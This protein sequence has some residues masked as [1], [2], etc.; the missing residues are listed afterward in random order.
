LD[1]GRASHD[2]I[3]GAGPPRRRLPRS[4]VVA[5]EALL[6][7]AVLVWVAV[8]AVDSGGG[9]QAAPTP[10]N[11]A[12]LPESG[13]V[14][15][16][17]PQSPWRFDRWARTHGRYTMTAGGIS[18]SY[19]LPAHQSGWEGGGSDRHYVTKSTQG[20]QGAEAII[21]WTSYPDGD[22]ADRC[23]N[24]LKNSVKPTAA[25]LAAAVST[26]SGTELVSGPV[27]VLVGGRA[28]KRVV[29]HVGDDVGCDPGYFYTWKP[30][31]WG[32]M[33]GRA[34]VGDKIQVWVVDVDGARLVIVGET[35]PSARTDVDQEI[36]RIVDSTSFPMD[37]LTGPG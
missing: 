21:Y 3:E 32:A 17:D 15:Q 27:D 33:W 2:V 5:V 4:L 34:G 11:V 31:M 1:P 25:S 20:P 14:Q 23:P 30:Y 35:S 18:F 19:A 22:W 24:V 37:S 28:A 8:V 7:A 6:A 13:P 36:Q 12:D 9:P 10:T 29:L 26:A 16:V